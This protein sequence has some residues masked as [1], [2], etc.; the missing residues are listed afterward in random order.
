MLGSG[1]NRWSDEAPS[2][3]WLDP[4]ASQT[5][6]GDE[7]LEPPPWVAVSTSATADLWGKHLGEERSGKGAMRPGKGAKCP[8]KGA[9]R[10]D[11]G[12]RQPGKGAR[13]PGEAAPREYTPVAPIHVYRVVLPLSPKEMGAGWWKVQVEDAQKFGVKI[14]WRANRIVQDGGMQVVLDGGKQGFLDRGKHGALHQGKHNAMKQGKGQ[15]EPSYVRP[16]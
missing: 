3:P 16:L 7:Q 4:S 12:A 14:T 9:E 15:E 11:K 8:G 5:Y 6:T 2:D 1:N 10:S 13:Q